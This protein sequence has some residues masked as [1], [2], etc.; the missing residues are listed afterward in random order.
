VLPGTDSSALG[1]GKTFFCHA[2]EQE[3]QNDR[4]KSCAIFTDNVPFTSML[5]A[6]TK[7]NIMATHQP[8]DS[9]QTSA[10]L[11]T[12]LLASLLM[13]NVPF[14]CLNAMHHHIT[15]GTFANSVSLCTPAPRACTSSQALSDYACYQL[16]CTNVTTH[17]HTPCKFHTQ[18]YLPSS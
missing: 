13:N 15:I 7:G 11:P 17:Y 5:R 4:R 6:C 10:S 8:C 18:Q 1:S 9:S 14:S 16:S 2:S 12:F 3:R